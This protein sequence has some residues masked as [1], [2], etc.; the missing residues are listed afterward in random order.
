MSTE[1]I[2][3][4]PPPGETIRDYDKK[5]S[6]S[7]QLKS[8]PPHFIDAMTVREE[9]FVKEQKVSS[10]NEVD[11]DDPRSFH[12]VVFASV[13]S[14]DKDTGNQSNRKPV[15]VLRLVPP[16]HDLHPEK[17]HGQETRPGVIKKT[18]MYDGQEPYAKLGRLATLKAYRGLG[19]GK[20]LVN[21]A[22]EWARANPDAILIPMSPATK[23]AVG[24]D[25]EV[26]W[27]GLFLIH[28][29][30]SAK[31]IWERLG[32]VRDEELGH[33]DEEGM[34]HVAMWRRVEV[35]RS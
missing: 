9:V 22:V 6:Y 12:W 19:L 31:R 2:V 33:W 18:T 10:E 4:L 1:F 21:A 20:L 17:A 5:L 34:D 28:A 26:S 14:A 7:D 13:S 15:G 11:D 32:F 8:I 29:Q 24:P 25:N 23:E 3:H 27:N 35:S 30:S 16:P